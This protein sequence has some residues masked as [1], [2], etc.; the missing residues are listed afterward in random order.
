MSKSLKIIHCFR[1]PVG[2]IFRHVRDLV[3]KQSEAGFQVGIIC[4]STTGGDYED[5]LFEK[6]RPSLSLGLHRI[7]MARSIAPKDLT[8]LIKT[9]SL[10]N[11]LVPDVVHSH[12]AKGGVY[13]RMGAWLADK[14]IKTFYCPHG[15]AMHYNPASLKGK[16]FFTA[17]RFLER[18]TTSLIFVS[19]YERNAYHEKVGKPRCPETIVYNGISPDEFIPVP[20]RKDACDFLY[21]GMKRDLKGPDIFLNALKM[22]RDSSGKNLTAWFVGDGPDE[23]K[24]DAQIKRL[25]LQ[26]CVY[27]SNAM[28]AR[29]AFALADIVVVPSRAESLPYL[30]L[31][32]LAA[33]KP[34]VSVNVGGIPEIF[35]DQKDRLVPTEDPEAMAKAMLE[36]HANKSR[37]TQAADMAKVLRKNFSLE[38]MSKS[39]EKLYS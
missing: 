34:M 20:L 26:E 29:E 30:V 32:A 38:A 13:G 23:A 25:Q 19:D 37:H 7:P 14:D 24:Y 9:R 6:I 35:A 17:E 2:G 28:P 3:N 22:A 1:S 12:S 27:V 8:A 15:G 5:E 4:D 11:S 31:E 39:V 10:I 33:Q 21:I 36:I 18:M 16:V